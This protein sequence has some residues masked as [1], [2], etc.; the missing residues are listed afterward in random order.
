MKTIIRYTLAV[1]TLIASFAAGAQNTRSGY[2]VDD[3]TYRF[4]LNPAFGNSRGF[5]SMPG[6]GNLNAGVNGNLN[7]DDVLYN[8]NGRTTTFMNPGVKASDFLGNI[9]DVSKLRVNTKIDIFS[10]GFKGFGGYNTINLNARAD[11]GLNLP[12]SL[13]SLLKEGVSNQTYNIDGLAARGTAYAEFAL[14]HSHNINKEWRI[15]ITAKFLVGAGN[16]DARLHNANLT[17]GTD[18]WTVT[19]DA[20]INSSLKGLTYKTDINN[21]TQHRYVNGADVDGAGIGGYGFAVDLGVIYK[22]TL[23]V[24]RD[25]TFSAAVLDLGFIN[26]NNN[27]LA[28]TNGPRTFTT[29][30]YIF[31]VDDDAINSFDNEWDKIKDDFGAI[32]ELDDMGDR[33]KRTTALGATV[34]VGVEY[35]F[36]LYR[37]LSFGLLNTTRINGAYGWTDFRLSANIAPVKCFDASVNVAAGTYGMGLGWLINLHVPGFNLFLAMDHT[38]TKVSKEYVPL[39]SNASVNFGLNFPF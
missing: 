24:L 38:V 33:G 19:S 23:P 37:R 17:L 6:I 13:F 7:V 20:E 22:P 21:L 16:I 31:N 11:V 5:V 12:K 29:D 32:Y 36:P 1:A 2:F 39:S 4:Q 28:S 3:Y 35:T 14:G 18:E 26:W 30:K 15:G 8:I 25:F 27:I 34:N 10:I 9:A